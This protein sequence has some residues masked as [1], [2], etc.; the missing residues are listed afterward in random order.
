MRPSRILRSVQ[1]ALVCLALFTA[2]AVAFADEPPAPASVEAPAA[3]PAPAAPPKIDSGDT[4]WLLMSSALVLAMTAPGLAIFYAG[5]VR[6]KNALN[7]I[8]Q[9]FIILCLI[10]LQWV[11]WG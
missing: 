10:S 9:C 3:V 2:S 11:L 1:L 8:M 7:T 5:M 4:A 6:K